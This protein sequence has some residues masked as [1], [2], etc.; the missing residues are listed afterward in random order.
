MCATGPGVRLAAGKHAALLG[1]IGAVCRTLSHV[2]AGHDAVAFDQIQVALRVAS[3]MALV[4]QD[5]QVEIPM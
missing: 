5:G 2:A 4:K 3:Y 1:G